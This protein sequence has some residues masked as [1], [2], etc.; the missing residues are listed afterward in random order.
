MRQSRPLSCP[1]RRPPLCH[2]CPAPRRSVRQVTSCELLQV[3]RSGRSFTVFVFAG[4][5][6][7]EELL[8][9]HQV[10]DELRQAAG[11][12]VRLQQQVNFLSRR[13][14]DLTT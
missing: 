11:R 1:S 5:G 8:Q 4:S 3:L 2:G 6:E 9:C 7:D 13:G 10:A 12:A 14:G